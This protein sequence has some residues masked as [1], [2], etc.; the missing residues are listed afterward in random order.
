[1]RTEPLMHKRASQTFFEPFFGSGIASRVE[2]DLAYAVQGLRSTDSGGVPRAIRR[3][4][5]GCGV[6]QKASAA[7][8]PPLRARD[9]A[10]KSPARLGL[11]VSEQHL[12]ATNQFFRSDPCVLR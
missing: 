7:A 6:T 4:F 1:M 12:L 8:A 5:G 10:T 9:L 3:A 2:H 11:P